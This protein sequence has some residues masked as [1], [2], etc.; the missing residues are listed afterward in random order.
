MTVNVNNKILYEVY[1]AE[2]DLSGSTADSVWFN[3]N[4]PEHSTTQ[5]GRLLNIVLLMSR[6]WVRIR[7]ILVF[8]LEGRGGGIFP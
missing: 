8:C 5:I 6:L 4:L 2:K 3:N 7:L 1:L